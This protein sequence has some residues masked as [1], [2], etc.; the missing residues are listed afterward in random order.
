MLFYEEASSSLNAGLKPFESRMVPLTSDSLPHAK[1][2]ILAHSED[3][4]GERRLLRLAIGDLA[5][6]RNGEGE[7]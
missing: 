3:V 5:K 4:L 7:C 6:K 2:F 1:H